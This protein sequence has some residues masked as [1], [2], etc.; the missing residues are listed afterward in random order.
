[1]FSLQASGRRCCGGNS[2]VWRPETQNGSVACPSPASSMA[3]CFPDGAHPTS[4]SF[5]PE[6]L[7]QSHRGS[8]EQWPHP[9]SSTV[10]H[11]WNSQAFPHPEQPTTRLWR[12]RQGSPARTPG[13]SSLCSIQKK[14]TAEDLRLANT[15][16][17]RKQLPEKTLQATTGVPGQERKGADRRQPDRQH[18]GA[19]EG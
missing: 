7:V 17:E 14:C 2:E 12:D 9:T 15:H 19:F 6:L 11:N 8:C 10:N 16:R 18:I 4:F 5:L 1:M 13:T 3:P